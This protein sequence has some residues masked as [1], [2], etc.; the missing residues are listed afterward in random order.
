MSWRTAYNRPGQRGRERGRS[1]YSIYIST[2]ARTRSSKRGRE[3]SIEL[4]EGGALLTS[5]CGGR[6]A[7]T[8][9]LIY[10]QHSLLPSRTRLRHRDEQEPY[11]NVGLLNKGGRTVLQGYFLRFTEVYSSKV[12]GGGLSRRLRLI[13]KAIVPF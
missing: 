7:N 5:R 4:S 6:L 3:V 13:F 9:R 12:K 2:R 8:I 10:C 11:R 1:S